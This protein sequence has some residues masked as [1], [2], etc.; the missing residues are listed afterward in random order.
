MAFLYKDKLE[1]PG[2]ALRRLLKEEEIIVAP[3]VFSPSV[4]LLAESMGFRAVYL[5][6][7]ALTGL[8]AMPDLG[9]I[10]LTEL[11]T[12]TKYITRVI[13][14]PLIVD[15]DTGFGEPINVQ[16]TIRELEDAGAAAI[17]IEDQVL[18]KKCGHL[19]GKTLVSTEDMVKKIIAAVDARRKDTLIIARTD[20]RAIEGLEGAIERAKAYVE[21]GADIIFPEALRSLE[22]FK[23]FVRALPNVPI[24]ANMTEFG[25]TPYI[26]VEEFKTAGVK[27]VIFPVTSF[28]MAMGAVKKTFEVLKSEGTQKSLIESETS[29]KIM[30]RWE[31]YDL[32]GYYSYEEVDKSIASRASEIMDRIKE[33]KK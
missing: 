4:A 33:D 30:S 15:A 11:A 12:A 27:I 2:L 24:L 17:Q 31:F 26:T 1:N 22:E 18:P 13:S 23:E 6:G 28:R 14:I 29:V 25:K 20:A 32:I 9:I 3:G 10:T 7:A 16:R 8:L 19:K 5:S 21:A